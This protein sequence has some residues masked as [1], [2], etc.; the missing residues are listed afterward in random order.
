MLGMISDLTASYLYR[1]V[2]TVS[3]RQLTAYEVGSTPNVE[4]EIE[5]TRQRDTL[6]WTYV[7]RELL[8][9]SMADASAIGSTTNSRRFSWSLDSDLFEGVKTV[10]VVRKLLTVKHQLIQK[11]FKDLLPN[12]G[13]RRYPVLIYIDE[14]HLGFEGGA[15]VK[16]IEL[17]GN[18]DNTVQLKI[19]VSRDISD[20][21]SCISRQTSIPVSELGDINIDTKLSVTCEC[22]SDL[23]TKQWPERSSE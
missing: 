10:K 2:G 6:V 17:L 22:E 18:Q 19:L 7:S 8:P 23:T 5:V 1:E 11:L 20:M 9:A 16:H 4:T 12:P 3:N 15:Y 14:Q 13:Y 21:M